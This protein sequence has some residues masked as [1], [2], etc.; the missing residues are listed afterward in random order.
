MLLK[1]GRI[2]FIDPKR[3]NPTGALPFDEKVPFFA[4]HLAPY[5]L[6]RDICRGKKI[7]EIGVGDGYGMQYLADAAGAYTGVDIDSA[8]LSRAKSKYGLHHALVMD[9]LRLGFKPCTFDV[10]LCFHIIEHI[11]EATVR[12]F[13]QEVKE[14]LRP[15]GLFICATPNA[16]KNMKHKGDRY[17]LDP[18]HAKEYDYRGL[19]ELLGGIFRNAEVYSFLPTIKH[20]FF[21]RLKKIGLLKYDFFNTNPVRKFYKNISTS[22]F[23][24]CGRELRNAVDFIA[25]CKKE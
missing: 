2:A 15:Q 4:K 3:Y 22:D 16:L 12:K 11:P 8:R 10:V 17:Q 5:A 23:R 1:T 19:K 24:I 9:G 13:L 14:V 18:L 7:L 20:D 25:A 21:L 6:V